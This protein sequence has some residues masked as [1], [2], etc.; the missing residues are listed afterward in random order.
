MNDLC[1]RWQD[2]Q[3]TWRH[4]SD[5]GFDRARYE[6]ALIA[7]AD[8]KRFV[9]A[10]HYSGSY[11]AARL[12]FGLYCAE[13]LVGVAVLS[14]PV[15]AKSLTSVFPGL[16]PLA[17]S[18]E[19]GR[20]VLL[21]AVPANGE[22]FFLGQVFRLAAAHGIRGVVSF[23]DPVPRRAG[24]G[25]LVVP[26]HVGTIYQAT[27][28]RYLGRGTARTLR[29]LPDGT[30]LNARS[31]Q[32]VRSQEQGHEHIERLLVTHGA[33]A[34]ARGEDPTAWLGRAL[35]QA[36]SR[37]VRHAGNHRY[38][39]VVGRT[40]TERRHVTLAMTGQPF[41]KSIDQEVTAA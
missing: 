9:V 11:P 10:Q 25:R 15:N 7:E 19:L 1:L 29:L 38:A 21:D 22:S 35:V 8:A 26:G 40:S 4:R 28:A 33:V 14:V 37:C 31:A 36:G 32:K 30:V 24:D 34:R 23:S 27:N 17:E 18:I 20:F 6:V 12:R 3:H 39:F 41:P 13:A 16:V 2:R 5:G